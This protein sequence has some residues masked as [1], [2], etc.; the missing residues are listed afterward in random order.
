MNTQIAQA[1]DKKSHT[2]N[3]NRR[4]LLSGLPVTEHTVE[5]AG[6]ATTVLTGGKG[7]PVILLH[8]PGET[9]V[10]WM[11]VISLLVKT[12]RVIVP[13]LPGHGDSGFGGDEADTNLVFPWLS[14]VIRQTCTSPPAVVGHILGGAIATRFAISHEEQISRLILVNSLGLGKFRPAPRFAFELL[15]FMIWPTEKNFNRFFPH[16][17][18]DV[19]DLQGQMGEK[20]EP[21]VKYNLECARDKE[22]SAALQVLMKEI[23][24]PT[25]PSEKLAAITVPTALIWGRHDKANRLS[26]AEAASQNFGWPLHIIEDTRDDPKLERPEAFVDALNDIFKE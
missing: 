9:S 26:I 16:C 6:I 22:Q 17:M 12:N 21:F 11:R 24:I 20:W 4:Q 2:S 8:G 14:D 23:G 7:D 3:K 13:D 19:E 5:A 10:W 18:Y 25:I 15:R 1:Q